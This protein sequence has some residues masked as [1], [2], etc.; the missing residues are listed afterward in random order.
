M[1]LV[2]VLDVLV[3]VLGVLVGVLGVLVGVLLCL[4]HA[5]NL[6]IKTN[7][8]KAKIFH[9]GHALMLSQN[10]SKS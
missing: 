9:L 2:G 8:N 4:K 3:G 7:L 10:Q 6:H 1:F 5:F